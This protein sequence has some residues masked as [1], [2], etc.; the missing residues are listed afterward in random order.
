MHPYLCAVSVYAVHW[1]YLAFFSIQLQYYT[2]PF[3][4]SFSR[5]ITVLWM[6]VLSETVVVLV[7]H[8]ACEA[9]VKFPLIQ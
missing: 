6:M 4:L 1:L 7:I 2:L 3:L 5:I 9:E 8:K